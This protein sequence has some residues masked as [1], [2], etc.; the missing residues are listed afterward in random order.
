MIESMES[1]RL[2]TA[3][4]AAVSLA[5]TATQITGVVLTFNTPLDA[6][7]AQNVDAYSI[8]KRTKGEESSFGGID[9]SSGGT[10]RRVS[11]SSAVYD[12]NAGTVTLTPTDP[13]DLGRKFRRLRITGVGPNAVK[14]ATGA[15]IDG[16]GNGQP[17]GSQI[18]HSRVV[19]ASHFF[20]REGDGD[21]GRLRLTG[22]GSLRVWSDAKRRIP[23]A[24]FLVGTDA[25][26]STLTGSVVRNR[27]GGDGI[28]TLHQV[29]GTAAASVPLL[30]DPAFRV[31]V[32]TP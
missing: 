6:A 30:T 3:P 7:S 27:R 22:P 11:F 14:E 20:F 18:V 4:L 26:R 15:P 8:S 17:G 9:T 25:T 12:A 23:P 28:V 32:V 31:D 10:T 16:D 24:V 29:S 21:R 2:L 5:G 13:F 1:R 19:R